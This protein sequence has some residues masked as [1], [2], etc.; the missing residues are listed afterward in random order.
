MKYSGRLSDECSEV[1]DGLRELFFAD[2]GTDQ[3]LQIREPHAIV[4]GSG[5]GLVAIGNVNQQNTISE[6]LSATFPDD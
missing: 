1:A 3:V 2:G 6:R 4:A 5:Q